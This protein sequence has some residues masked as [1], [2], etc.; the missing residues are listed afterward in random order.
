MMCFEFP[1]GIGS[2]S[3]IVGEHVVG[4]LLLCNFGDRERLDLPGLRLDPAPVPGRPGSC[5][6]V[7]ATDAP[8]SAAQLRRLALRPLLGLARAGSYA[9]EGSGE[10]GLAFTTAP[11]AGLATGALDPY[12]AAAYEAAHE[13][14]LNCLVAARP[15]Q[16]L[17]GSMLEAFPLEAVRAAAR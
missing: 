11:S 14:V 8:L 5:I 17:D 9:A 13:A 10:I 12:F 2:A 4:V 1:G 3:R 15:A 16:R 6:A 7:C